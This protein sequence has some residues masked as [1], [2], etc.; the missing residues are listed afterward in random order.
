LQLVDLSPGLAIGILR[1][2]YLG[3]LTGVIP[4]A[5]AWGL[6]FLFR[7]VTNVTIPPVGVL[8]LAVALAGAN[9]GVLAIIDPAVQQSADAPTLITALLVVMMLAVY[10]HA[11]GDSLGQTLP[12]RFAFD[13]TTLSAEVMELVGN[14]GNVAVEIVPP[15]E[16]L[17]GYPSLP[18]DLRAE[19]AEETIDL[20]ADLPLAEL[21]R[22]AADQLQSR[23]DL[24]ACTVEVDD[25]ARTTVR[26]APPSAGVSRR[27]PTGRRAV[28]VD[29]LLPTGVARG[30]SVRLHLDDPP[31]L[32]ADRAAATG[33]EA[34]GDVREGRVDTPR[35]SRRR[36]AD[37]E[38]V[39]EG[40]V[41]AARTYL[42]DELPAET[43]NR[44]TTGGRGRLTVATTRPTVDRLLAAPTVRTVVA[45]R[46]ESRDYDTLSRLRRAGFRVRRTEAGELPS[47]HGPLLAVSGDG[48]WTFGS[49]ITA[50]PDQTAEVF[51]LADSTWRPRGGGQ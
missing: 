36:G 12:R 2:V 6:G 26:A 35:S 30:D 34:N 19:I 37:R 41:V 18:E 17:P 7:Y 21:E 11:R 4:A 33:V 5:V 28:S 38:R 43:G 15:V 20:P 31:T 47:D 10:A 49:A 44:S 3:L 9:G 25:A 51:Y 45:S 1:G 50:D 46:G 27:V 29:T 24:E 32:S 8:V 16:D 14:R 40:T 13:T 39:V 23:F 22:R 42:D 48:S